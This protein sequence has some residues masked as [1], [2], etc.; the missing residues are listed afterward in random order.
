[1]RRAA[2]PSIFDCQN[3]LSKHF[4]LDDKLTDL[5]EHVASPADLATVLLSGTFGYIL[6]VGLDLVVFLEP[7]VMGIMAAT[8]ALGLKKAHEA[9]NN[10]RRLVR[11]VRKLQKRSPEER[12]LALEQ[13]LQLYIDEI[14]DEREMRES[15]RHHARS[16][17]YLIPGAPDVGLSQP[18]S[19]EEGEDIPQTKPLGQPLK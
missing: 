1:M 14:L 12:R 11:A 7:S 16:L 9:L 15:L 8:A 18:S 4:I 3:P 10:R 5:L 2:S 13:D 19:E 17:R 6:E